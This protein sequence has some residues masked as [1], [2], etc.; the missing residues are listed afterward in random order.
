MGPDHGSGV[1]WAGLGR[2]DLADR[3]RSQGSHR[4]LREIAAALPT[5]VDLPFLASIA[6]AWHRLVLR[7]ER[8]TQGVYVRLDG[9]VWRYAGFDTI[10]TA[11]KTARAAARDGSLRIS[12]LPLITSSWLVP[13]LQKFEDLCI[14]E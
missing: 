4:G 7:G 6:V 2:G 8:V 5:P 1:H 14:K 13:R 3:F 10:E 11:A 12:A 9:A